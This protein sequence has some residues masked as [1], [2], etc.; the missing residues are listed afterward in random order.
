MQNKLLI[1]QGLPG[2]GKSTFTKTIIDQS[3]NSPNSPKWIRVNRDDLRVMCGLEWN[4]DNEVFIKEIEEEFVRRAIRSGKNVVVDDTNLANETCQR[5]KNLAAF[6]DCNIEFKFFYTP[7]ET[8]I[9]RDSLRTNPVGEKIIR[10]LHNKYL[11]IDK[12]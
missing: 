12:I 2:S 8:C 10:N 5:W 1:L 11:K 6:L 9:Y 4:Q 7:L 3:P